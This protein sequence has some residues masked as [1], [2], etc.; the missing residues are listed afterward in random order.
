M[1]LQKF[2]N[3]TEAQQIAFFIDPAFVSRSHLA[4]VSRIEQM[5]ANHGG[6]KMFV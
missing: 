5:T 2:E 6:G 4:F 3:S 1:S